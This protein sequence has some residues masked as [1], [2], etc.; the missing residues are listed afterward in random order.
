IDVGNNTG[1]VPST[2]PKFSTSAL[3]IFDK[4][5]GI[6]DP[7]FFGMYNQT[8]GTTLPAPVTGW[9]PEI[10]LDIEWAHAIAPKANIIIVEADAAKTH[11][12]FTAMETAV[13]TLGAS[14]VSMSFGA[15]LEYFGFGTLEAQIDQ[16]YFAPALAANPHVTFLASTGDDGA[17]P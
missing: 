5:F 15:T 14:V 17:F 10:A 13:T 2:D 1:F 6:P 9:G 16:T 7:P 4:T 11:D 3:A 8:G 12:L